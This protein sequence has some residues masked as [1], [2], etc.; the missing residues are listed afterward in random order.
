MENQLEQETLQ[1]LK[2]KVLDKY[3]T[4]LKQMVASIRKDDAFS[5]NKFMK[6]NRVSRNLS[7]AVQNMGMADYSSKFGQWTSSV[8][9]GEV[10]STATLGVLRNM[11][12][13]K[14]LKF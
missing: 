9:I 6:R 8:Q 13:Q 4:V 14:G 3:R 10:D 7:T 1:V 11:Y 5:M 12:A 2:L